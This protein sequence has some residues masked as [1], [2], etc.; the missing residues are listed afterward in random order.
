MASNYTKNFAPK[1]TR[2]NYQKLGCNY[3]YIINNTRL[4]NKFTPNH[5]NRLIPE[6][7]SYNKSLSKT[8][9]N[10]P[11]TNITQKLSS[12]EKNLRILDDY[13]F[14]DLNDYVST[15]VSN[16]KNKVHSKINTN[17]ISTNVCNFDNSENSSMD[18]I[19]NLLDNSDSKNE[20]K[21][22]KKQA[23]NNENNKLYKTVTQN[24][25]IMN[26]QKTY[27][28][29]NTN[30]NKTNNNKISNNNLN[31][32]KDNS[33]ENKSNEIK[34]KI[35]FTKNLITRDS[36]ISYIK[37]S[38]IGDYYEKSKNIN[39]PLLHSLN[40]NYPVKS[41]REII[42]PY[43]SM[44]TNYDYDNENNEYREDYFSTFENFHRN[45]VINSILDPKTSVNKM[46]ITSSVTNGN[47]RNNTKE[48]IRDIVSSSN[49]KNEIAHLHPKI[50]LKMKK[51]NNY[52]YNTQKNLN[53]NNYL[54][55]NSNVD[56]EN[57]QLKKKIEELTNEI[58]TKNLLIKEFSNLAKESKNKFDLIIKNSQNQ[59]KEIKNNADKQN[60][61]LIVK[62][63]DMRSQNQK[64]VKQLQELK[65]YNKTME[66][67]LIGKSENPGNVEG[68]LN[69]KL[70][71]EIYNLKKKLELKNAE[72]QKLKEI[73]IGYSKRE[74][75]SNTINNSKTNIKLI[76]TNV[77]LKN[78][79]L[80]K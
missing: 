13:N 44:K 46:R 59:I 55:D 53:I 17:I 63:N 72:N 52:R 9:S 39:V 65:N 42:E 35:N 25:N 4:K 79:Y 76:N 32:K 30:V 12:V 49:T 80:K 51:K 40:L 31:K 24:N 56:N 8:K 34:K 27:L 11:N 58:K 71:N 3:N 73:L 37:T 21:N 6:L 29:N 54:N 60:K 18:T 41:Y 77:I 1:L 67:L 7:S 36:K 47:L 38:N 50:N 74:C 75:G 68:D 23:Q 5:L 78:N 61:L 70:L 26:F 62:I 57:I 28:K 33:T 15:K 16:E 2:Q 10:I 43:K 19:K 69:K 20:T 64:L 14:L 66:E 48:N 22:E 45:P